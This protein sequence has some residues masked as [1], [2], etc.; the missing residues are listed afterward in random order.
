MS[1]QAQTPQLPHDIDGIFSYGVNWL[2]ILIAILTALLVC[3]IAYYLIKRLRKPQ[4]I[5]T[6]APN[7]WAELQKRARNLSVANAPSPKEQ[8]ELFFNISEIVRLAAEMF[9]GL[10]LTDRTTFEIRQLLKANKCLPDDISDSLRQLLNASERVQF[11][12]EPV[13]REESQKH[14]HECQSLV[15]K[16][17][18]LHRAKQEHPLPSAAV[19]GSRP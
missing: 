5:T 12:D 3:G 15:D 19:E 13:T 11:A 4:S 6:P 9:S 17:Y 14:L 18:A 8:K 7:P 1:S 2:G 16:I 10:P